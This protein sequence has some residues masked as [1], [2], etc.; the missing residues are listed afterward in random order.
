MDFT[1]STPEWSDSEEP[2]QKVTTCMAAAG[3]VIKPA[4]GNELT[5]HSGILMDLAK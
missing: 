5:A 3:V 4:G 2:V 1:S